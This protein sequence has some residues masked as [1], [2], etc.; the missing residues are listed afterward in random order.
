[1]ALSKKMVDALNRQVNAELYASYL[2]LAMDSY[3]ESIN[4]KGFAGWMN[5]QAKEELYHASIIYD[6][7]NERGGRSAL[8][9][10]D[11]PKKEWKSPLDAFKDAY[12]HEVM[13]TGM[14]GDLVEMATK[15]KDHATFNMLQWF[16]KEQVEEEAQ[17]DEAVKKLRL[18]GKDANGLFMLDQQLGAR[19]PLFAFPLPGAPGASGA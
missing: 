7:I 8:A 5:A 16:V 10:I 11:A 2:Y 1:M 12:D 15:E 9:A 4:L 14:I 18:I 19:V 6:F 3:F 13:V 17:T